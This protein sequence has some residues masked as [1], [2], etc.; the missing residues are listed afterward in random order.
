[1]LDIHYIRENPEEVKQNILNRKVDPAKADVGRLLLLDD[2]KAK[3]NYEIEQT[4]ATRNKL[5]EELKDAKLRTSEKIEEGKKIREGIS[6]LEKELVGVEKEWQ[7]LMD[8]M[9]NML[10]NDVPVGKGEDDNLEIKAWTV[11]DGYFKQNQLGLKDYSKKW[12][13]VFDFKPKDHLEIG[14]NL[15]LIDVEQSAKT[16]GSRFA[17]LKDDL[18]VMQYALFDLLNGHI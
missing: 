17:Y 3:L 8:W 10:A 5:A 15:G 14:V 18:V 4:R 1:M 12:M 2:Q 9:P 6:I 11:K 13:P 16:S 7:A